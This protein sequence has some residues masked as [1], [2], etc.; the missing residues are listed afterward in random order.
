MFLGFTGPNAAGKGEAIKY[1]VEKKKFTVI[2]LSDILR[3]E[4]RTRGLQPVRENLI[5]IGNDLRAKEG[6]SVLAKKT[7]MKIK[8]MPQA[9]V[10]SIR[11]PK[12]VDEL[13]ASLKNFKLVGVTAD[14]KVRFER[15]LKRGRLGDGASLDAFMKHEEQENTSNENA[16]QLNKCFEMADIK[17]D[18][19]GTPEQLHA[20]LDRI[21]ESL[22]YAAYSRPTW[23]EYFMKMAYLVA[24]R[25][26]CLR[27]HVGAVIVKNN[28]VIST[29][30]NGAAAGIKDCTELGCLRDQLGIASGTRHEICRAIHAEQN[31]IIQAALHGGG[32]EGATVYCTHSP[33]IICAK[34]V[35]NSKIK[36]FVTSNQYPDPGYQE[37]FAEAGVEFKVVPRPGLIITVL[38]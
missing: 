23:D 35:V 38:D 7:V 10:D 37:L 30:Y 31:A 20:Q 12:E 6:A 11:N 33:C 29:G 21:L 16:Q 19:S 3:E 36:K 22:G 25:S 1:L 26:T 24:E 32:T 13:R 34:M 18:N 8:N 2:S 14:V 5:A 15:A 27:H 17:V 4:A 28:Y 9:A